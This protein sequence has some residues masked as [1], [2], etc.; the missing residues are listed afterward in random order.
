MI[1]CNDKYSEKGPAVSSHLKRFYI[2][3]NNLFIDH[4]KTI[5]FQNLNKNKIH[6]NKTGSSILRENFMKAISNIFQ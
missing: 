2:K 1:T 5:K 6:L 3:E 4:K